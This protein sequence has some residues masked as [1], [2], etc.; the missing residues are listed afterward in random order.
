MNN[1]PSMYPDIDVW[2]CLGRMSGQTKLLTPDTFRG[3]RLEDASP[4][5][6]IGSLAVFLPKADN[7][8]TRDVRAEP[9][10]WFTL[11]NCR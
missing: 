9:Y 1:E 8:N 2:A 5:S 11:E 6:G 10:G 3:M 7:S 4:M